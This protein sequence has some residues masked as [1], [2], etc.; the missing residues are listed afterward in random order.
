MDPAALRR[1]PLFAQLS[2]SQLARI[3]DIARAETYQPGALIFKEHDPGDRL[4]VILEG[5][6]RISRQIPAAGEEALA[7]LKAGS[8]FGE[9]SV[10]DQPARSTDA[11]AHTRCSL[12]SIAQPDLDVLMEADH[13]LG[14]RILR[15]VVGLMAARLRAANDQVRSILAMSM[16]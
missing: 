6:V 9:M 8:F 4:F 1:A 14:Y 10:F 16:F 15:A 7:I 11:I 13:E 3:A 12:A 2:E 5:E